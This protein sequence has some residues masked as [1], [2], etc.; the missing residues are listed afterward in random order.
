MIRYRRSN[1]VRDSI[2][3][4]FLAVAALLLWIQTSGEGVKTGWAAGVS[5]P[6]E[7]PPEA[8]EGRPSTPV[9]PFVLEAHG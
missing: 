5:A 1:R 7:S 9:A 2:G 3:V 4:V 6:A 8:S